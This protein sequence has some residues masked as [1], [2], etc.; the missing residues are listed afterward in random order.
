MPKVF[1]SYSHDSKE[2][3]QQVLALADRLN[4]NDSLNSKFV[5]IIFKAG[6]AK[7][8]PMSLKAISHYGLSCEQLR[9]GVPLI[10]QA[11]RSGQ[12]CS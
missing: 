4:E 12:T 3:R 2:H 1:I 11:I 5:P 9:N 10:N 7:L 6:D 8:V